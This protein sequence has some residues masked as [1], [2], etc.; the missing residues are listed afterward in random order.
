MMKLKD[1]FSFIPPKPPVH[2]DEEERALQREAVRRVASG[3]VLL[4]LGR[5]TTEEDIRAAKKRLLSRHSHK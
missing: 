1:I 2:G 4:Q 5:F 3:N